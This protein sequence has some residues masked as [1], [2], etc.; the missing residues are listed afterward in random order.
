M[1]KLNDF[2]H[3]RLVH[4]A[5]T[6]GRKVI[7]DIE[8]PLCVLSQIS[9]NIEASS[10]THITIAI[11]GWGSEQDNGGESWSDLL[12]IYPEKTFY[13]LRWKSNFSMGI[14]KEYS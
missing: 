5:L 2:N 7:S 8:N 9:N 12:K 11:S 13:S 1:D 3:Q 4:S 10:A 6:V 14:I